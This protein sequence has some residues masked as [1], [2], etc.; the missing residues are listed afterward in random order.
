MFSTL[1]ELAKQ[2]T[3]MITVAA[4]G[5]DQLRVNVTPMPFDTKAKSKLPQPL[6]LL[7]TP[8]EFDADFIAALSTWQAPKRT[9]IQQAQDAAGGAPAA[10]AAA[11][12]APKADSKS[13]KAGRKPRAG[14][15]GDDDKKDGAQPAAAAG[16]QGAGSDQVAAD[17]ASG[18]QPQAGA[19]AGAAAGGTGG[20]TAADQGGEQAGGAEAVIAQPESAAAVTD[21]VA[22]GASAAPE[23]PAGDEPVDKFTLDLF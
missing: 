1:H 14:K 3:L 7:A 21:Q 22:A 13:E 18:E 6:S 10:A 20:D 8:T 12:P 5:D 23:A 4:E 16:D 17:A 19:D 9:L 2:A 15:G 11:L